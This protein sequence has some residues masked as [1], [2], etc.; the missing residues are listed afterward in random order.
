MGGGGGGVDGG[1]GGDK[2]EEDAADEFAEDREMERRLKVREIDG[3]KMNHS[4][5]FVQLVLKYY[6]QDTRATACV[7]V[8]FGVNISLHYKA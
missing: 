5:L 3:E 4:F 1:G 8:C 2:E 7:T 6:E